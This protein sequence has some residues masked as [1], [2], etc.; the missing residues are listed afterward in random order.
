MRISYDN[1]V[2]AL[3]IRLIEG[4]FQCRTL[5]LSDTVALNIGPAEQLVGVEVLEARKTLQLDDKPTVEVE[6]LLVKVAG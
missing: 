5:R 6:N 3:Y 4:E 1:S 2:D